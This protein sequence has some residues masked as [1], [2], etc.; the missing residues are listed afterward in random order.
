MGCFSTLVVS[1]CVTAPLVGVLGYIT[2]TGNIILGGG[3][4][5]ALGLGTGIP[6]LIIGFSAG[7]FLPQTESWMEVIRK[8]FGLLL[9][10]LAIW[11]IERVVAPGVTLFLWAGLLLATAVYCFFLTEQW[12]LHGRRSAYVVGGIL[13]LY[14]FIL[15]FGVAM[16]Y[17]SPF[18]PFERLI[19]QQGHNLPGFIEVKD[20]NH[21]DELFKKAR[22]DKKPVILDSYANWCESCQ[23]VE[24]TVLAKSE[25][26]RILQHFVLLRANISN[27]NSFDNALLERYNV[28]APPTFLFFNREGQELFDQRIIGQ[29]S[30]HIFLVHASKID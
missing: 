14:S 28:V 24:K 17:T 22:Q 18:Y 26:Q 11:M 27:N 16:N 4:L 8:I 7:K 19:S 9:V 10:G 6:L 1:P 2:D 20:M 30:Y 25:M 3:A 23:V 21:L 5:F 15:F 13:A 29:A 12:F